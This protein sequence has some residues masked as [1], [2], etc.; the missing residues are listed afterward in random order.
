M[1]ATHTGFQKR[2]EELHGAVFVLECKAKG[3]RLSYVPGTQTRVCQFRKFS[4][5]IQPLFP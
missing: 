2:M 1:S 5:V 4:E 3:G